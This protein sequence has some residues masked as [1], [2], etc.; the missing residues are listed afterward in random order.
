[1]MHGS[2][3]KEERRVPGIQMLIPSGQLHVGGHITSIPGD[4]ATHAASRARL[5]SFYIKRISI[6]ALLKT[7]IYNMISPMTSCLLD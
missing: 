1:M 4:T 2:H 3:L 6:F 7:V 5:Q